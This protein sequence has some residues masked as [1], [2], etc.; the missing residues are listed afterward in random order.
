M[1]HTPCIKNITEMVII[2]DTGHSEI[3]REQ[4][5]PPTEEMEATGG[6]EGWVSIPL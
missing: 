2:N 6:K 3:P 1:T 4:S 5:A